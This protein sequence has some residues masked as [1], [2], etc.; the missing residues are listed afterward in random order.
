M[1]AA[2]V[3]G[4]GAC[5]VRVDAGYGRSSKGKEPARADVAG[6][7]TGSS[8]KQ[9]RKGRRPERALLRISVGACRR[10]RVEVPVRTTPV[11]AQ[12]GGWPRR[13]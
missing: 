10:R 5:A 3:V 13:L 8:R 1:V 6:I 4:R 12:D 2:D 11:Q 7:V 9:K